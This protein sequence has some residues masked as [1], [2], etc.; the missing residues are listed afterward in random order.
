MPNSPSQRK[1]FRMRLV[2]VLLQDSIPLV[3]LSDRA[4]TRNHREGCI[5]VII[6]EEPLPPP[7]HRWVGY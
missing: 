3:G 5:D 2:D 4:P 6:Q 7:P 1:L